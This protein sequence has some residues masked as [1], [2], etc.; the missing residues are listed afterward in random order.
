MPLSMMVVHAAR[1]PRRATNVEHHL[2]ELALAHL[3]VRH[4][5]RAP[6]GPARAAA[7]RPG[8]WSRRGCAR[9]TTCPP[10]ASS[11]LD[12]LA[13]PA[14][15]RTRRRRCGWPGGPRG[16]VSMTRDV[17]HPGMS[18]MC[19][20]RGMGVAVSVSTSTCAA[21]CFSCSFCVT[22]KRCSSSTTTSPRSLDRTSVESS[23]WVPTSTSTLPVAE[24]ASAICALL[25]WRCGSARPRRPSPGSRRSARAKVMVVLLREHRGRH[26]HR[27]LLAGQRPP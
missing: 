24:R 2:L 9:R 3:P 15:R 5:A 23:R 1:R 19:S 10:R 26:Q 20:V 8:R 7:P 4:A 13:R 22:P 16:G 18:A 12:G 21:G 14:R 25:R 27:H 6:R 11:L 17:A